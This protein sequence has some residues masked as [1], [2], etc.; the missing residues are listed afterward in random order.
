MMSSYS[1]ATQPEKF[2]K[3]ICHETN[4]YLEITPNEIP[5]IAEIT[6]TLGAD[7]QARLIQFSR[8]RIDAL[9]TITNTF[10]IQSS[11][12]K[13][14]VVS[15]DETTFDQTGMKKMEVLTARDPKGRMLTLKINDHSRDGRPSSSYSY[16][17]GK[18]VVS[19]SEE[20]TQ[21][22]CVGQLKIPW[23]TSTV[24]DVVTNK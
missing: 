4:P 16:E 5:R 9:P 8:P 3:I 17:D 2:G 11:E 12:I 10:S 6:V 19:N 7:G 24:A 22:S 21:L 14:D 23:Q 20:D 15:A 1:F 13:H 18:L